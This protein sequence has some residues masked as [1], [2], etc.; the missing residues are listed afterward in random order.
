MTSG[1]PFSELLSRSDKEGVGGHFHCIGNV[2]FL[3]SAKEDMGIIVFFFI[4][5][6]FFLSFF[7]LS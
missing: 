3:K 2:W 7:C 1:S 4:P 5:F 6:S